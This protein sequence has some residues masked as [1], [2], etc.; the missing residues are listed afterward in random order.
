MLSRNT[1]HLGSATECNMSASWQHLQHS[2]CTGRCAL[3]CIE[4]HRHASGCIVSKREPT[5]NS[6]LSCRCARRLKVDQ[7]QKSDIKKKESKKEASTS[8]SRR[9]KTAKA[10]RGR[11]AMPPSPL[12]HDSFVGGRETRNQDRRKKEKARRGDDST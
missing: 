8:K 3:M 2:I 9:R 11:S 4:V 10:S 6:L 12:S 1:S 7:R 5:G